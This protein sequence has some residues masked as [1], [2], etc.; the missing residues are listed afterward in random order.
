[1]E[2]TCKRAAVIG[3]SGGIG[4]ATAHAFSAIGWNVDIYD[5]AEPAALPENSRYIRF[6]LLSDD[7]SDIDSGVDALVYTA[8]FGRIARFGDLTDYEISNGFRV[9]A[10]LPARVL[11][12]FMP[13]MAA[14]SSG[15]GRYCGGSGPVLRIRQDPGDAAE[16]RSHDGRDLPEEETGED[17]TPRRRVLWLFPDYDLLLRKPE[18]F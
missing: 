14:G 3:G 1:M 15:T 9:N 8:G 5:R 13:R 12:A 10:E 2:I 16:R 4:L 7:I 6:N 17:S 18:G 11:S